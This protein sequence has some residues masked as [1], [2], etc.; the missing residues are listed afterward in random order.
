[1]GR[2]LY[3]EGACD[4]GHVLYAI[5]M[6]S[7]IPALFR[8]DK[9]NMSSHFLGFVDRMK[10]E[11]FICCL[12][13][14]YDG[15]AFFIPR[16]SENVR[17]FVVYSE[18]KQRIEYIDILDY[19]FDLSD[20][21]YSLKRLGNELWIFPTDLQK[22]L[23]AFDMDNYQI[24]VV[25]QW[26]KKVK[27]L[28][29]KGNIQPKSGHG[30]EVDG[31]VY[32]SITNTNYIVSINRQTMEMQ[33]HVL[34]EKYE[35]SYSITHDGKAFWVVCVKNKGVVSWTPEKGVIKE[36]SLE[37][38]INPKIATWQGWFLAI[39]CGKNYV[40][41]TPVLDKWLLRVEPETGIITFFQLMSGEQTWNPS[42]YAAILQQNNVVAFYPRWNNHVTYLDLENDCILEKC[43]ILMLPGKWTEGQ[44]HKYRGEWNGKI[45][46]RDDLNLLIDYL[47]GEADPGY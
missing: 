32:L 25:E 14:F 44:M 45:L 27:I 23:L 17:F 30:I 15:T 1:M 39:Y 21:Y 38:Y 29:G 5:S 28:S 37:E 13:E 12:A 16:F 43:D 11:R 10:G 18:K 9:E 41:L 34:P 7:N 3:I 8:I 2:E 40:W 20:G 19:D 36:I 31:V 26:K 35:L 22:D 4:A 33:I 46:Y 24:R 42:T 6:A 47:L